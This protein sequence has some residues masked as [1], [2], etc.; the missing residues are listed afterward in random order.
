MF[1]AYKIEV[2]AVGDVVKVGRL[3]CYIMN[4]IAHLI[5]AS[6]GVLYRYLA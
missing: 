3:R 6:W 4:T 5:A 2:D 1:N